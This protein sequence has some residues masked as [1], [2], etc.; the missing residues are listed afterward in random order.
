MVVVTHLLDG[1]Q[2]FLAQFREIAEDQLRPYVEAGGLPSR[3][4]WVGTR[5][6]PLTDG[7]PIS[8][9]EGEMAILW[10]LVQE[11]QPAR[12]GDLFTGTG[13]SAVLL[14]SASSAPVVTADNYGEGGRQS[15][16]YAEAQALFARFDL[17]NLTA[18]VGGLPEYDQA[19]GGEA[20][21]FVFA[22]G[23]QPSPRDARVVAVHDWNGAPEDWLKI[24]GTS[25][26]AVRAADAEDMARVRTVVDVV[27]EWLKADGLRL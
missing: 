18:V 27:V 10:A 14:A 19:T 24:D 15:R 7:V 8:I 23:A 6:V 1:F 22:D 11:F 25:Y 26:L 5:Y 21:E 17:P 13:V 9:F 2:D 20:A 3:G 4:E 16:G 12:I